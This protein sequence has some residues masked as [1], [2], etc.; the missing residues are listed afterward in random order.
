MWE[1]RQRST[2]LHRNKAW[3]HT[4]NFLNIAGCNHEVPHTDPLIT[5]ATPSMT[6]SVPVLDEVPHVDPLITSGVPTLDEVPNRQT[7]KWFLILSITATW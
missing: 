4:R 5:N 2:D 3:R 1:L 7:G 6:K